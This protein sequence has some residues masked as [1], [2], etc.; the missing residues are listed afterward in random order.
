MSIDNNSKDEGLHNFDLFAWFEGKSHNFCSRKLH[1]NKT[2]LHDFFV[3]SAYTF[4]QIYTLKRI[5]NMFVDDRGKVKKKMKMK[6]SGAVTSLQKF[7][8]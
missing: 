2:Y 1:H 7:I 6:S 3:M 5:H 8:L 4:Y